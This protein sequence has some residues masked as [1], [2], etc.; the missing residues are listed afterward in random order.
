M[1]QQETE[2]EELLRQFEA[3]ME[4]EGLNK[5]KETKIILDGGVGKVVKEKAK[6]AQYTIR[7]QNDLFLQ[8]KAI[9]HFDPSMT[10]NKLVN[11]GLD[12]II[13]HY[14]KVNGADFIKD[15]LDQN[16]KMNKESFLRQREL[17]V[18]SNEKRK[19]EGK[20]GKN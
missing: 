12:M 6:D 1:K 9:A 11:Q 14:I 2:Q 13:K 4:A 16:K 10:F 19:N 17:M 18:R 5:K 8:G 15:I 7:F 20:G 3:F